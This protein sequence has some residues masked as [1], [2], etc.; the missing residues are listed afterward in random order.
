MKLCTYR[1]LMYRPIRRCQLAMMLEM[2]EL[3]QLSQ[4]LLAQSDPV[5][6]R[7]PNLLPPIRSLLSHPPIGVAERAYTLLLG[8]P[9]QFIQLIRWWLKLN[10]LDITDIIIHWTR[11]LS[12]LSLDTYLKHFNE[13]LRLL[14][15]VSCLLTTRSLWR[16]FVG[17]RWR[18]CWCR[19]TQTSFPFILGLANVLICVIL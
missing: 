19:G 15:L 6:L 3:V 1:C 5:C 9:N 14:L 16:D 18:M 17:L 7:S 10:F 11:L 2:R 13:Y 4:P 8:G 12:R